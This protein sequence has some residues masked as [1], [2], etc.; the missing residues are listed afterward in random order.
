MDAIPLLSHPYVVFPPAVLQT[1]V[2]PTER[3]IIGIPSVVEKVKAAS[4]QKLDYGID[5]YRKFL[6]APFVFMFATPI[7]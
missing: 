5:Y 3:K 7:L 6:F 1:Q 4:P 2:N